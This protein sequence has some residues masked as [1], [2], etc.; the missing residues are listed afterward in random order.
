MARALML[1]IVSQTTQLANNLGYQHWVSAPTGNFRTK[2]FHGTFFECP[3][4]RTQNPEGWQLLADT[5]EVPD[6]W[7]DKPI[8]VTVDR[9]IFQQKVMCTDQQFQEAV[10]EVNALGWWKIYPDPFGTHDEWEATPQPVLHRLVW[11]FDQRAGGAHISQWEAENGFYESTGEL[12]PLGYHYIYGLKVQ[13]SEQFFL[14]GQTT[15]PLEQ[16]LN[17]H[18]AL[19]TNGD[20]NAVIK[21]AVE[22]SDQVITI[23]QLATVFFLTVAEYEVGMALHLKHQGHPIQ[24]KIL[25]VVGINAQ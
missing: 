7:L 4:M 19:G 5:K 21:A 11:D 8:R 12:P 16:R 23:E 10:E 24:N 25:D 14:I 2:L 17:Q 20:A 22:S 18:L 13:G 15:Q 1:F 9:R 6:A 3:E